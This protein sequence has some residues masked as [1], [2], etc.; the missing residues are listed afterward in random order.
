MPSCTVPVPAAA[1]DAQHARTARPFEVGGLERPPLCRG[2]TDN[3]PS[4]KPSLRATDATYAQNSRRSFDGA[5][6]RA[7]PLLYGTKHYHLHMLLST[8]VDASTIYSIGQCFRTC[9]ERCA[10]GVVDRAH[11]SSALRLRSLGLRPCAQPGPGGR[12]RH[13]RMAARV[14]HCVTPPWCL[15]CMSADGHGRDWAGR[16]GEGRGWTH[17]WLGRSRRGRGLEPR[18]RT[19]CS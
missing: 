7:P 2:S 17:R 15:R 4:I 14:W 18:G 9:D 10:C 1:V 5:G 19:R 12:I 16:G 13:A 8:S 6:A 3:A 11:V